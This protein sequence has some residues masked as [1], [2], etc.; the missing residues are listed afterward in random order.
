[1]YSILAIYNKSHGKTAAAAHRASSTWWRGRRQT[2]TK[3]STRAARYVWIQYL[4]YICK[5]RR[6]VFGCRV[7]KSIIPLMSAP[8]KG[9]SHSTSYDTKVVIFTKMP[10]GINTRADK[11]VFVRMYMHTQHHDENH[12]FWCVVTP[13]EYYTRFFT[14]GLYIACHHKISMKSVL[15]WA[16]VKWCV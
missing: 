1:M 13:P 8:H 7:C 4:S 16:C 12:V 15:V 6:L 5:H 10:R 3:Q 9:D 14:Y 11:Y 2:H